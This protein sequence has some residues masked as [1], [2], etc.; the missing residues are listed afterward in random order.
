VAAYT[1]GQVERLLGLPSST[2]RH[3]EREVSLLEPRKDSFGRRRYSTS[4]L[5]ILFR[6]RHLALGRGLGLSAAREALV[7]ELSAELPSPRAEARARLAEIRTELVALYFACVEAGRGLGLD[8]GA[9]SHLSP[10]SRYRRT[11]CPQP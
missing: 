3:W 9:E 1:T 4:D 10:E 7:A 6:L 11:T 8:R 5:R 2:L